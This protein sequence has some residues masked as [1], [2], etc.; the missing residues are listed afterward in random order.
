VL[1]YRMLTGQLFDYHQKDI[2]SPGTIN[3]EVSPEWDA[4]VLKAIARKPENR[5]AH[6]QEMRLALEQLPTGSAELCGEQDL[7]LLY[8]LR[9]QVKELRRDP[10][11]VMYKEIRDALDLDE[12]LHP[13]TYVKPEFQVVSPLVA[14][15]KKSSLYWQRRGAGFT[16]NWAQAKGYVEHLNE[17]RWEGR[18]SWRL[19]TLEELRTVLSPP[20]HGVA[21]STWPLFDSTIH[22]LWSSD[23]CTK[24]QAWMAD[25]VESFFERLDRDGVASVCAVSS[26]R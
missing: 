19:P 4:F 21:C 25:V 24:K 23:Y 17:M 15:E 12:L 7:T 3:S 26:K 14:Y 22:W 13:C 2:A 6:C 16:L 8:D 1:A 11:R 5:F 9:P 20:M 10:C 18:Q